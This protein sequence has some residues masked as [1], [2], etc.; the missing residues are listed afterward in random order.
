MQKGLGA[1]TVAL[2]ALAFILVAGALIASSQ[3]HAIQDPGAETTLEQT[4]CGGAGCEGAAGKTISIHEPNITAGTEG[5]T[6][7]RQSAVS[8]TV[9]TFEPTSPELAPIE[10]HSITGGVVEV[11]LVA[12]GNIPVTSITTPELGETNTW[13]TGRPHGLVDGDTFNT[14]ADFAGGCLPTAPA[15]NGTFTVIDVLTTETFTTA[16]TVDCST[17]PFTGTVTDTEDDETLTARGD[18]LW[19]TDAAHML[20]EGDTFEYTGGTET[21]NDCIITADNA[22]VVTKRVNSKQFVTIGPETPEV[23]SGPMNPDGMVS[24]GARFNATSAVLSGL[25]AGQ[26]FCISDPTDSELVTVPDDAFSVAADGDGDGDGDGGCRPV[27]EV[28]STSAWSVVGVVVETPDLG[29][30]AGSVYGFNPSDTITVTLGGPCGLQTLVGVPSVTVS[31]TDSG[32]GTETYDPIRI[33]S[34]GTPGTCEIDT[35]GV[36]GGTGTTNSKVQIVGGAA[37]IDSLAD[38]QV[39][40]GTVDRGGAPIGNGPSAANKPE[41]GN[42][43]NALVGD[44][45]VTREFMFHAVDT[46]NQPLLTGTS[47]SATIAAGGLLPSGLATSAILSFDAGTDLADACCYTGSSFGP[48]ATIP[49]GNYGWFLVVVTGDSLATGDTHTLTFTTGTETAVVEFTTHTEGAPDTITWIPPAGAGAG[50]ANLSPN[51]GDP[52]PSGA[53]TIQV[54]DANGMGVT[55]LVDAGNL[56]VGNNAANV[57]ALTFGMA[58]PGAPGAY[59]V[60]IGAADSTPPGEYLVD[61]TVYLGGVAIPLVETFTVVVAGPAASSSVV[62]VA[63][64]DGM[65]GMV[66]FTFL[67]AAGNPVAGGSPVAILHTGSGGLLVAP[68]PVTTGGAITITYT[69][70]TETI[71]AQVGTVSA[72]AQVDAVV[73]PMEIE[74]GE[75]VLDL[76]AGGQ[77]VFA[78]FSGNAADVFGAQVTI[79]WKFLGVGGGWISF[80]PDL[81]VTDYAIAPGDV[82]WVVSPMDQSILVNSGY[83]G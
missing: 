57:D 26:Q 64:G 62:V 74:G 23:C 63:A 77:F 12:I 35:V 60:D 13:T 27:S 66:T 44:P 78:T 59:E 71:I 36:V 30:D 80:F 38:P 81:G 34:Q 3:S 76:V 47:G 68:D 17:T 45:M 75:T 61:V 56:V 55:G 22:Y 18:P 11:G 72:V 48:S 58:N 19:T 39:A 24:H 32:Q 51:G 29:P 2:I 1:R 70:G 4:D 7:A 54:D 5:A 20:S 37:R 53:W 67:D 16:G 43:L 83:S 46:R 9:S 14:D 33:V 69:A 73:E 8:G 50:D 41:N 21:L 79:A 42:L 82:L 52:N 15:M 25:V 28:I 65:P 49:L 31:K 10:L 40:F 6:L